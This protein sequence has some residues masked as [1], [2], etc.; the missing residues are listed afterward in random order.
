MDWKFF[1]TNYA[2]WQSLVGVVTLVVW[3]LYPASGEYVI[4]RNHIPIVGIVLSIL[5]VMVTLAATFF[6]LETSDV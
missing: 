2:K 1:L 5:T 3:L 6:T 4:Q